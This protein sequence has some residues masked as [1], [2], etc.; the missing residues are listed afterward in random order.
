MAITIGSMLEEVQL[1]YQQHN[2]SCFLY[3]SSEVIKVIISCL[4]LSDV[5]FLFS[6]LT[7]ILTY[8]CLDQIPLVLIILEV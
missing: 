7:F 4:S 3:L 6:L 5:H 1:L 8:R 2:Q